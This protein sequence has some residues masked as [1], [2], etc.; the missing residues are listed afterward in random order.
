MPNPVQF[1]RSLEERGAP[2]IKSFLLDE[3]WQ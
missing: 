1:L 3:L 2:A